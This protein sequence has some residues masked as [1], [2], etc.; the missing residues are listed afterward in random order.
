MFSTINVQIL[1]RA[2]LYECSLPV[3]EFRVLE[4]HGRSKNA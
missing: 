2:I 3:I 4:I 1:S